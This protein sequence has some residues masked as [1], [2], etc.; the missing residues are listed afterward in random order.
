MR[1][2]VRA[3]L[4]A[5]MASA[6]SLFV[7][8]DGLDNR[9][10]STGPACDAGA[11]VSE[12]S[13]PGDAGDGGDAS[14]I[15][16]TYNDFTD[17]SQWAEFD[18]SLLPRPDGGAPF[19]GYTGAVSDGRYVYFTPYI[20]NGNLSSTSILIR[21]DS[22]LALSAASSWISLD[23]TTINPSASGFG[24][25]G[26]DGR[27][28]YLTPQSG[29]TAL[30]Y[31]TQ[32]DITAAGSWEAFDLSVLNSSAGVSINNA[33]FAGNYVYFTPLYNR[34]ARYDVRHAFTDKASWEMLDPSDT[35]GFGTYNF[36]NGIYDGQRYIYSPPEAANAPEEALRLDTTLSFSSSSAW[37]EFDLSTLDSGIPS[38]FESWGTFDGRYVYA[39]PS[40]YGGE[41]LARYDTQADFTTAAGWTE[42]DL[43][44]VGSNI[45]EGPSA[46]DG[47]YV[48]LLPRTNN[49][50]LARYDTQLSLT[51]K[52]SW[53]TFD[54]TALA[55]GNHSFGGSTFDGRFLYLAP[56]SST[57]V[58]RFDARDPKP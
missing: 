50:S 55:A 37:A 7:S 52:A 10:S 28:L 11:C 45:Q 14:A 25:Q 34:I 23:L 39:T 31:D 53:T 57:I 3:V 18:L 44:T 2:L 41:Q 48:Y 20:Y 58:Y 38:Q 46:F 30:R 26:F 56:W 32:A 51:D 43:S 17:S 42:L 19:S 29:S 36:S 8:L 24:G 49:G 4:L 1:G 5:M 16:Y 33:I 9:N 54:M 13:T 40:G 27:Y 21:Y 6:C 22:T 47:R 12:S 15:S 35:F